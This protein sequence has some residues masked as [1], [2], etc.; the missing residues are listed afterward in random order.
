MWTVTINDDESLMLIK[1]GSVFDYRTLRELLDQIYV[2]NDGKHAHYDRFVDLTGLETINI[3]MDTVAEA[4]KS[5][6]QRNHLPK[7]VKIA[8]LS[9]FG[10]TGSLAQI[11]KFMTET[12]KLFDVQIFHS[13]EAC[14]AYLQVDQSIL[15]N[16]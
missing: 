3:D 7:G 4:A 13:V 8:F 5:Y 11:Y 14:A 6:R 10:M 9:P 1:T 15:M 16:Q 12:D 2:R